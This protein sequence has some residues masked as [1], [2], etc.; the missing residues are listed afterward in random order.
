MAAHRLTKEINQEDKMSYSRTETLIKAV[1]N[2]ES[3]ENFVPRSRIEAI[4]KNCCTGSGTDGIP[5]PRSRNEAL[6][7]RLAEQ[8]AGEGGGTGGADNSVVRG[9]V[10]RSITE[11]SNDEVTTIGTD[12]FF[13]CAK[14]TTVNIP[15]VKEISGS[16]FYFC[17]L[18]T[19]FHAPK[20]EKFGPQVFTDCTAL[21][22]LDLPSA[23]ELGYNCFRRSGIETLILRGAEMVTLRDHAIFDEAP[24]TNG[25]GYIYAPSAL[26]QTYKTNPYW[27]GF[28]DQIRAI[29]DYPEIT[30]G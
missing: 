17:G 19:T 23:K 15:N 16:A 22:Y 12:A 30:G 2:G 25:T 29:E 13:N 18:L 26:V 20:A 10:E 14:L 9:I 6:L 4:L 27:V 1:L 3:L 7:Y 28:A 8:L 5:E 11:F 21:K 24:I